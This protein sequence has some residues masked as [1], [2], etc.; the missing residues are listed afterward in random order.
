MAEPSRSD[1]GPPAGFLPVATLGRAHGLEGALRVHPKTDSAIDV[2]LHAVE[3]HASLWLEGLG[4]VRLERFA[5][6][7]R[8]WLAWFDRVHRRER[9]DALV[10]ATLYA[11]VLDAP[12]GE[13]DVWREEDLVGLPVLQGDETLGEIIA[14]EGSPLHPLLRVRGVKGGSAFLPFLAPYVEV[15]P[16]SVRL[17]DPPE[18]LWDAP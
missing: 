8:F 3:E 12:G 14:V 5:P 7:G 11:P 15:T 1:A 9:A 16:E 18:G 17:V 13:E 6:H 10:H 2:L 4:E